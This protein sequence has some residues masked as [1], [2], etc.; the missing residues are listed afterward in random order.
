MQ[1][2]LKLY[3]LS[4]LQYRTVRLTAKKVTLQL[5]ET[6][7]GFERGKI[8]LLVLELSQLGLIY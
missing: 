3:L 6:T 5:I 2:G 1:P 4:F 7:G 8:Q